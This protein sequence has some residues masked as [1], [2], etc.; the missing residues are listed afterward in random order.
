MKKVVV[1]ASLLASG[2]FAACRH[3]APAPAQPA[4]RELPP[5]AQRPK[6][7]DPAPVPLG[8]P[9]TQPAAYTVRARVDRD[10]LVGDEDETPQPTSVKPDAGILYDAG[11]PLPPVPDAPPLPNVRDAGQPMR[12][13]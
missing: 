5:V 12:G 1:L 6:R 7:V 13:Q 8:V 3:P 10:A 2:M 4:P 11:A 9:T